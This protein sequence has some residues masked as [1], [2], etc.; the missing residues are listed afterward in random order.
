MKKFTIGEFAKLR[1]ININSL[2]YYERLGVLKPAFTDPENRYRYY[3]AEQLP[4]L[5]A[6]IMC[7]EFGIPLKELTGYIDENGAVNLAA[8][9]L[10]CRELAQKQI[11]KIQTNIGALELELARIESDRR[12]Y[13]RQGLYTRKI[14]ERRIFVGSPFTSAFDEKTIENEANK[15]F[16]EAQ[17]KNLAP[18]FPAGM[19]IDLGDTG[20]EVRF[21]VEIADKASSYPQ[22][23]LIPAGSYQCF[24]FHLTPSSDFSGAIEE[25]WGKGKMRVITNNICFDRLSYDDGPAEI[26]RLV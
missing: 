4:L 16:L 13:G 12:I 15:V 20:F 10:R 22:I 21:F 3:T 9:L 26:Q 18:V 5:N 17:R 2:R 1:G 25:H 23:Y 14:E 24:Q 6:V 19:L 11:K 7:V 8:L